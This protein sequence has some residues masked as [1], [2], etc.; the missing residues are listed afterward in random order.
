MNKTWLDDLDIII[1]NLEIATERDWRHSGALKSA[2][3][4]KR[5]V[6]REYEEWRKR[7][8]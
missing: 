3:E 1:R 2:R 8:E 5:N 4:L 6:E 7:G